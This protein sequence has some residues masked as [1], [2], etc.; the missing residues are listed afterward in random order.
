MDY[1][2]HGYFIVY[3][4]GIFL[5]CTCEVVEGGGN[6]VRRVS[7][8]GVADNEAGLAHCPVPDQYAVDPSLRRRTGPPPLHTHWEVLQAAMR[9][10]RGVPA[11][12]GSGH[13]ARVLLHACLGKHGCAQSDGSEIPHP[14]FNPGVSAAGRVCASCEVLRRFDARTGATAAFLWAAG[15]PDWGTVFICCKKLTSRAPSEASEL[16]K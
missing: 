11:A 6:I 12:H 16:S 15:A 2:G 3:F 1:F 9:H 10:R 4:T 13:T 14:P 8:G 5:Q 7:V